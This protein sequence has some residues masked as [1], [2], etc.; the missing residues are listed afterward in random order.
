[1]N[2]AGV[3]LPPSMEHLALGAYGNT[4]TTQEAVSCVLDEYADA[5]LMYAAALHD[6]LEREVIGTENAQAIVSGVVRSLE[7]LGE[8]LRVASGTLWECIVTS[9]IKEAKS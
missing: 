2:P 1:M 5:A 3:E 8:L 4:R 9:D 7:Q 6:A